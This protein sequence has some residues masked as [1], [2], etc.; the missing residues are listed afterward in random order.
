M[1]ETIMIGQLHCKGLIAGYKVDFDLFLEE[2]GSRYR[3]SFSDGGLGAGVNGWIS[4]LQ[5]RGTFFKPPA[6]LPGQLTYKLVGGGVLGTV[7]T[8]QLF[9]RGHQV[10]EVGGMGVGGGLALIKSR[11]KFK[12]RKSS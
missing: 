3:A 4:V 1:R 5:A 8:M 2:S 12:F 10:A 7:L 6:D 11:G 9:E